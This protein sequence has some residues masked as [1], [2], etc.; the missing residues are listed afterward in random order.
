MSWLREMDVGPFFIEV[1]NLTAGIGGLDFPKLRY[2]NLIEMQRLACGIDKAGEKEEG[3]GHIIRQETIV[4]DG[5]GS[6]LIA[7]QD[8]GI[9]EVPAV[10]II[11]FKKVNHCS[12]SFSL[13]GSVSSF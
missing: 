4:V 11:I 1:K 5:N 13:V 2:R 8:E 12:S 6:I 3:R 9:M 10:L 7:R